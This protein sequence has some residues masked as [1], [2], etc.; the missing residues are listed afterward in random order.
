MW[1]LECNSN[2]ITTLDTGNNL[3]LEDLFCDKNK[4]TALDLSSNI[5]LISL[6]CNDNS[7]TELNLKNNNNLNLDLN[8]I[9]FLNNPNLTC[10]QVDDQSYSDTN[11]S[12]FKDMTASYSDN[13]SNLSNN[14]VVFANVSMFPNP[15]K[16]QLNIENIKLN[17]VQ[18]Y[19][20]IGVAVKNQTFDGVATNNT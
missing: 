18:V 12:N 19:T 11:W 3:V 1:Y 6:K 10:I 5:G 9:N 13:C 20:S 14:Q 8:Y 2:S 7:L 17:E 15:T 4:L 16:G